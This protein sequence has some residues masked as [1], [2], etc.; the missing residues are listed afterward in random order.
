MRSL[1]TKRLGKPLFLLDDV[2]S[3]NDV[4]KQQAKSGAKEGYTVIADRQS[5]GRGSMGR[6]WLSLAGK[7]V[8]LS[9]LLRPGWPG[10]DSAFINMFSAVAV[11]HV[12]KQIGLKKVCLKWPNDVLVNGKK[13]AGVLIEPGISKGLIEFAVVGI[14][15][16]VF[17]KAKDLKLIVDNQATSCILEGAKTDCDRIIISLLNEL[18]A[19]YK[20]TCKQRVNI[21][22]QWSRYSM[23][24][25]RN[26]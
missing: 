20:L 6:Q 25:N 15:L 7:G 17:H 19:C 21:I 8:Y 16:N 9:V 24:K 18:D 3:T 5:Q 23:V 1:K 13:I 14:G 11:A 12:L 22:D 10:S 26:K 2:V 4:V